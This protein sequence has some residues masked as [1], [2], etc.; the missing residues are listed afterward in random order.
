MKKLILIAILSMAGFAQAQN[1]KLTVEMAG[2][3]SNDGKAKVGLYNSEKLLK[4]PIKSMVVAIKDGKAK[5]IFEGLEKG[6]YAVSIY[7]DKNGNGA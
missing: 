3:G 2:F 4:T 1:V 7:H 5:A 6:E